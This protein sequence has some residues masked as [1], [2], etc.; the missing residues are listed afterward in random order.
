[1]QLVFN[2]KKVVRLPRGLLC[3]GVRVVRGL[4]A[5][6]YIREN[7]ITGDFDKIFYNR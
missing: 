5:G 2:K 7:F 3:L 4:K 6:K 1:M